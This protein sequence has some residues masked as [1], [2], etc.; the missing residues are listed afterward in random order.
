MRESRANRLRLIVRW[1]VTKA[2]W[3][4]SAATRHQALPGTRTFR[5]LG[6]TTAATLWVK[7][8]LHPDRRGV[9]WTP[10]VKRRPNR[11]PLERLSRG[12]PEA[13]GS[14]AARRKTHLPTWRLLLDQAAIR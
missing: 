6:G 4:S 8:F 13:Q 11:S 5:S 7:P 12:C 10:R 3:E 2:E 1:V 14:G 9:A